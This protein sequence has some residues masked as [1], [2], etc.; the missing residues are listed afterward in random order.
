M[1]NSIRD[2]LIQETE[3]INTEKIDLNK[4]KEANNKLKELKNFEEL[5][6]YNDLFSQIYINEKYNSNKVKKQLEDKLNILNTIKLNWKDTFNLIYDNPIRQDIIKYKLNI[7]KKYIND[8]K[9]YRSTNN[10]NDN[11]NYFIESINKKRNG[12]NLNS[13]KMGNDYNR[14]RINNF[15]NDRYS[16]NYNIN[17]INK[18]KTNSFRMNT[19]RSINNNQINRRNFNQNSEGVN[20]YNYNFNP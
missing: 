7:L 18:N 17:E 12:L 19:N 14:N 13:S 4:K 20:R 5:N 11:N 16:Y 10:R 15:L 9:S 3:S 1:Y 6:Q 2:F 8:Y